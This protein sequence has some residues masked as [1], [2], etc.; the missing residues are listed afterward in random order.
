MELSKYI[1]SDK[2]VELGIDNKP[3]L[4]IE[5]RCKLF[6]YNLVEPLE[7]LFH[8]KEIVFHSG[9]R[10]NKLNTALKGKPF[11]QHLKGN[12]LDFTVHGYSLEYAFRIIKN[13]SLIFDQLLL[14]GKEGHQWLHI[15]YNTDLP[16]SKQRMQALEL[17]DA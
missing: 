2:A 17:P 1:S 8:P 12:A 14:E 5:E 15:S 9:Y 13:S 7:I 3:V 6:L 10:C 16:A 4:E 11:S